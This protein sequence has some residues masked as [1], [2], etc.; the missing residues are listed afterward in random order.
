MVCIACT[1]SGKKLVQITWNQINH[2]IFIANVPHFNSNTFAHYRLKSFVFAWSA[3]SCFPHCLKRHLL[4]CGSL[5]CTKYSAAQS[6]PRR[7]GDSI[8]SAFRKKNNN[9][10]QEALIANLSLLNCVNGRCTLIW[11]LH[12]GSFLLPKQTVLSTYQMPPR[13]KRKLRLQ[14]QQPR[15]ANE[16]SVLLLFVWLLTSLRVLV[17]RVLLRAEAPV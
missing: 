10:S 9:C 2:V 8:V 7:D 17:I 13:G 5:Q 6:E 1:V 16:V 3:N 4:A 15:P 14:Q 12:S 11:L